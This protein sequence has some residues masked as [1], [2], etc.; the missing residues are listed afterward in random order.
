M[1]T[2]HAGMKESKSLVC[3]LFSIESVETIR[4]SREP[5]RYPSLTLECDKIF[6]YGAQDAIRKTTGSWI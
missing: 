2:H 3:I 4:T 1:I 6:T 5:E